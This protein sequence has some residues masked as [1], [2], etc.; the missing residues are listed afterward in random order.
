V[1][2]SG[3]VLA[4]LSVRIW[5]FHRPLVIHEKLLAERSSDHVECTRR[6]VQVEKAGEIVG[7][8]L[9]GE[10]KRTL[11]DAE[12]LLDKPENA[13]EVVAKVVNVSLRS[14]SRDYHQRYAEAVLVIALALLRDRQ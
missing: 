12:V 1:G 9:V 11:R 10:I 6:H 8:A 5:R 7:G 2:R 14:V 3:T 4:T 13:P